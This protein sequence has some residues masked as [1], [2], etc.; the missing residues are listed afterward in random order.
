MITLCI[1][2]HEKIHNVDN[3]LIK[4]GAI[5]REELRKEGKLSGGQ[6]PYGKMRVDGGKTLIDN[7]DEQEVINKICELKVSLHCGSE[8]IKRKLESLGY[9]AR[10]GHGF[11]TNAILRILRSKGLQQEGYIRYNPK[12]ISQ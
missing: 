8:T 1:D 12:L 7:P 3:S 6:V 4:L 11:T 10:K 2:C 9:K 5:K